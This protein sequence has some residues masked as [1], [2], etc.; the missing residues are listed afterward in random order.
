M[1]SRFIKTTAISFDVDGTL[2]DFEGAMRSAL[3]E[4]LKA[5]NQ[6]DPLAGG[7]LNVEKITEARKD[8]YQQMRGH[9]TDLNT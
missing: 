7:K 4:S 1:H 6:H 2:W 5:L 9:I 8:I 3:G